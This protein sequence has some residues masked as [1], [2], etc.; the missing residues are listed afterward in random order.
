MKGKTKVLNV[1]WFEK[2]TVL[3]EPL[4][5]PVDQMPIGKRTTKEKEGRG[6]ASPSKKKRKAH[7]GEDVKARTKRRS[8]RKFHVSYF[9]LGDG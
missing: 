7:E 1:V 8:C 4:V 3:D 2:A 9:P 6:V 5:M